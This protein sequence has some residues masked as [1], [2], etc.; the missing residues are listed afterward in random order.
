[1]ERSEA[2]CKE[3][4]NDKSK[5]IYKIRVRRQRPTRSVHAAVPPVRVSVEMMMAIFI[6]V[7]VK[8]VLHNIATKPPTNESFFSRFSFY[9]RVI[10]LSKHEMYI[11]L[12]TQTHTLASGTKKNEIFF[13]FYCRSPRRVRNACALR[14]TYILDNWFQ[15]FS[16]ISLL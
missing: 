10:A 2:K 3:K 5:H 7:S 9:S 14:R 1:M 11:C 6:F 8:M 15:L 16:A 4:K 13:F 12:R